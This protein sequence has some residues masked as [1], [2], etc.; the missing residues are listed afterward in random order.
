MA[1]VFIDGEK[2]VTLRGDG[3]AEEF[4]GLVERYVEKRF[5]EQ[6]ADLTL[7]LFRPRTEKPAHG[8]DPAGARHA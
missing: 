2:A 3:I 6:A 8:H 4:Q 1:P 5:G 7:S